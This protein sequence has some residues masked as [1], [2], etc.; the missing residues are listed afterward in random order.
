MLF[1][2]LGALERAIAAAFPQA[3]ERS[4]VLIIDEA[5][6]LVQDRATASPGSLH[7][8]TAITNTILIAASA[9]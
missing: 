3:C 8:V 7:L 2:W 4:A 1:Y 6:S 5:D 9:R